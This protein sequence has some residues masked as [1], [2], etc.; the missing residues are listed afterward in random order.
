MSDKWRIWYGPCKDWVKIENFQITER[1]NYKVAALRDPNREEEED[2]VDVLQAG[3]VFMRRETKKKT[4]MADKE[5]FDDT[6]LTA[7]KEFKDAGKSKTAAIG[8]HF[9][10]WKRSATDDG[11]F[12]V[13]ASDEVSTDFKSEGNYQ[14]V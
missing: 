4:N 11:G 1:G 10:D 5:E 12:I 2:S 14:M 9:L 6:K 3:T 7:E 8:L 13:L